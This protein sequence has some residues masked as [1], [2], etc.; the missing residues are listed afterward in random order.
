[1]VINFR[2]KHPAFSGG[3]NFETTFASLKTDG[4]SQFMTDG[5]DGGPGGSSKKLAGKGFQ[6]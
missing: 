2:G 1:M 3:N 4:F 5:T 6:T